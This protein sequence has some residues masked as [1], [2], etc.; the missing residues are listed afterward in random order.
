MHTVPLKY[1]KRLQWYTCR[2]LHQ[3]RC[4]SCLHI[5]LL[6]HAGYDI[7]E[8]YWHRLGHRGQRGRLPSNF[9]TGEAPSLQL[10]TVDAV[11]LYFCLF[12]HVNLHPSQKIVGE[13]QEFLVLSMGYL[14]P[15]ET[16]APPPS[17]LQNRS[18]AYAYW[19]SMLR[20]VLGMLAMQQRDTA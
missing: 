3:I 20:A 19:C 7:N 9:W 16:F 17:Q 2:M 15:Q 8:A 1:N 10:W 4:V 6:A 14:R 5:S 13:I 18:R 12:L 11:H